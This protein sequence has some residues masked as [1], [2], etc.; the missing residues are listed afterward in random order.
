MSDVTTNRTTALPETE[1][2]LPMLFSHFRNQEMRPTCEAYKG[3]RFSVS[4]TVVN[5]TKWSGY[6]DAMLLQGPDGS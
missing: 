5:V 4:F 2:G 6:F 1:S 3:L